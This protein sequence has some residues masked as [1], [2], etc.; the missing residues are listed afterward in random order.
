MSEYTSELDL[1]S[2]D[3]PLVLDRPIDEGR[4]ADELDHVVQTINDMR[5]K[6]RTSWE[7]LE[8][9]NS[10]RL[11]AER[12]AGIGEISASIAHEIR[13]PLASIVNAIE[14]LRRE[15]TSAKNRAEAIEVATTESHRL[16]HILTEFLQF[17]GQQPA[18]CTRE[19]I[20]ELISETVVSMQMSLDPKRAVSIDKLFFQDPCYVVC[21]RV[22]IRQVLWNLMLNAVQAMPDGGALSIVTCVQG[23]KIC[24]VVSDTG[25]GIEE[26]MRDEII[27]PF[28]TQR[29]NGTGL[30]LSVAQK[31]LVDHGTELSI[32]SSAGEG[33]EV[34]FNLAT[35]HSL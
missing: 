12:L 17:A 31:I 3:R 30:G 20:N 4:P 15:K 33:T 7:T 23:D 27:K 21:D 10:R 22:Q 34:C 28:V 18:V 16:Q 26:T 29:E 11:K 19:N 6:I 32:Y 8:R 25:H 35:E 9:E 13:N 14:L 5:Q 2:L 1:T 24:V